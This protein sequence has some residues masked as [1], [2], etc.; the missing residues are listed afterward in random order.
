L[1]VRDL[2][3][4]AVGEEQASGHIIATTDREK[5][6]L[7]MIAT[8]EGYRMLPVPEDVGGRFSVLSPVGL[9]PIACAG[10]SIEELCAGAARVCE[11]LV[12]SSQDVLHGAEVFAA[13]HY[14]GFS[15]RSQTIHVFIPYMNALRQTG[16]WFR[17]LWAESLGKKDTIDGR[18]VF[19]GPTPVAALG[20]TDQHSQFQ[21]YYYGPFDKILTFVDVE[22]Y[23]APLTVP[24]A[25]SEIEGVS[26]M[27]GLSFEKIIRTE[28]QASAL[29]LAERKRPNGRLILSEKNAFTIGQLLQFLEISTVYMGHLLKINPFDQPGVELGKQNMYALFGRSGYEKR[30]EELTSLMETYEKDVV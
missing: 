25:F 29:A 13:L 27:G 21:L 22:N 6:T 1:Y 26:Y 2:I 14:L 8:Q 17:Q 3:I 12:N 24:H 19:T 5:G 23:D 15:R 9:F 30:R 10:I 18:E 16:F 7:R 20:A 4:Q 11:R 28:L